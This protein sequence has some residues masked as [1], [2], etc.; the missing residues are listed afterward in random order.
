MDIGSENAEIRLVGL[1][2]DGDY[3]LGGVVAD[4]LCG[5]VGRARGVRSVSA[6]RTV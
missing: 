4:F 1:G 5:Y 6:E 2:G 3:Y